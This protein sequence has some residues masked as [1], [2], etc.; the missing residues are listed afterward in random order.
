[1]SAADATYAHF[2]GAPREIAAQG[3]TSPS[4]KNMGRVTHKSLE[5]HPFL[6]SRE[7]ATTFLRAHDVYRAS[8]ARNGKTR[9]IPGESGALG[10]REV[11]YAEDEGTQSGKGKFEFVALAGLRV[12]VFGQGVTALVREFANFEARGGKPGLG[13]SNRNRPPVGDDVRAVARDALELKRIG[14][15]KTGTVFH[16]HD[17]T[18]NYAVLAQHHR[19]G[20]TRA[21]LDPNV[22]GINRKA[23]P[24]FTNAPLGMGGMNGA[25]MAS[26]AVFG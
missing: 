16:T 4:T 25:I 15:V 20:T 18:G 12:D 13:A 21:D 7:T 2:E 10:K 23:A 5:H 9:D 17:T 8:L 11:V 1:M 14:A 22:I 3:E 24:E 19:L 26:L 6:M